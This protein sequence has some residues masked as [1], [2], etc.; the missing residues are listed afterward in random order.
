MIQLHTLGTVDLRR[1]GEEVTT[2][3]AQP[4]RLTLLVYLAASWPPRY[5]SR[6]SLLALFWPGSEPER[7][8]NALRQALHYLRRA[9]GSSAVLSRGDDVAVNGAEVWCDAAVFESALQQGAYEE[10]VRLYGGEFMPGVS[11]ED[12]AG[13]SEW[14]EQERLRLQAAAAQAERGRTASEAGAAPAEHVPEAS[15]PRAGA[16]AA[17]RVRDAPLRA[18]RRVRAGAWR[19]LAA[20]GATLV[21]VAVAAWLARPRAAVAPGAVPPTIAVLPFTAGAA[22][23]EASAALSESLRA[24]LSQLAGVRVVSQPAPSPDGGVDSIARALHVAHVLAGSVSAR[25]G[26]MQ[27]TVQLLETPGG[28]TV[29]RAAYDRAPGELAALRDEIVRAVAAKLRARGEEH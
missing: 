5:H 14:L 27:V 26:R 6:A 19:R 3:L 24:G 9:L 2:V 22:E 28:S 8:R 12:A 10:A 29:W 7:G 20:A 17:A 25:G 18:R 21:I 4:K 16:D 15:A 1:D 11:V 13:A 23:A